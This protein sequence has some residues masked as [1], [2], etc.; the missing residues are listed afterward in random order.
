M[1]VLDDNLLEEMTRRLVA[2]FQPEQIILFG[3]HAWGTPGEDSDIDLLVIVSQSNLPPAQRDMRAHLTMR[4]LLA[5]VDILVKTRFEF[6]R[7][8]HVPASLEHRIIKQGK[9]LY[10]RGKTIAQALR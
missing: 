6:E 10:G 9:V 5:P 4:G 3:S 7:F 8:N 2:E 1:K